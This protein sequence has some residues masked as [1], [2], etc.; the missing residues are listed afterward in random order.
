MNEKQRANGE[1]P[2]GDEEGRTG[3]AESGTGPAVPEEA[4][5]DSRG[6]HRG[7]A[8]EVGEVEVQVEE[9]RR[10]VEF[11]NDRHLRLAAEFDN[12]RRRS[13]NQLGEAGTVAQARLIGTLLAVLDDLERVNALDPEAA[14]VEAV[15]EGVALVHRKL[16]QLLEEAG[17]ETLDPEGESFDPTIMEALS[18]VPAEDPEEDDTV[19]R[20]FQRGF[21]F[22]G[23]LVRPARVSVRKYE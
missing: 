23:H 20:V 4:A 1:W 17:L 2:E 15:L 21:L 3:G 6:S 13:Q 7:G 12:Y 22:S 14:S 11:L 16:V 18:R 19:E 5:A 10:E 9:L 8:G